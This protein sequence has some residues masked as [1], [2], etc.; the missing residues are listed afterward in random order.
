MSYC[1]FLSINNFHTIAYKWQK[2]QIDK[3]LY[4]HFTIYMYIV[5]SGTCTF[6][7]NLVSLRNDVRNKRRVRWLAQF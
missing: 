1:P 3:T 5:Y 6:D 4:I 7:T 2:D